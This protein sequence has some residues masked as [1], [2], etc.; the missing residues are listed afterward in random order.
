MSK[1][2]Q[3]AFENLQRKLAEANERIVEF[4]KIKAG[5]LEML[6]ARD[7][8]EAMLVAALEH[9]EAVDTFLYGDDSIAAKAI[10]EYSKE[11]G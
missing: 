7:E 3:W 10:A 4:E 2:N 1:I 11:V 6:K 9:Y 8:R 5:H